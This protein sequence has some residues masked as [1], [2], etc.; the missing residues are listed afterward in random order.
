[1][2]D[3]HNEIKWCMFIPSKP[4]VQLNDEKENA[5][6]VFIKILNDLKKIFKDFNK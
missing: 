1:M 5:V 3:Q 6:L 2:I 4:D